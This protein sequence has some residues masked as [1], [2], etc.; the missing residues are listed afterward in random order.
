M[1]PSL[2]FMKAALSS[3]QCCSLKMLPSNSERK[4]MADVEVEVEEPQMGD[5]K[6]NGKKEVN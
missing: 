5:R 2:G 4:T 3:F 6:E 1:F